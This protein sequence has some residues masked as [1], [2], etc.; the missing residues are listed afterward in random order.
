MRIARIRSWIPLSKAIKPTR[1]PWNMGVLLIVPEFPQKS[2]KYTDMFFL[3]QVPIWHKF[4]RYLRCWLD[5]RRVSSS[6]LLW[7]WVW[8]LVPSFVSSEEHYFDLV[9]LHTTRPILI[10]QWA[11]SHQK[12]NLACQVAIM[13]CLGAEWS[14]FI[15][16]GTVCRSHINLLFCCYYYSYHRSQI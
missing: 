12:N 9:P 8:R 1:A 5:L 13:P 11:Q 2:W 3:W 14:P 16:L 10:T 7:L 4:F 15:S 6:K